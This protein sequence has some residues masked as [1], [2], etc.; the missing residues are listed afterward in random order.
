[1]SPAPDSRSHGR[2]HERE[3]QWK[4]DDIRHRLHH[5]S[6]RSREI[7]GLLK[8]LIAREEEAISFELTADQPTEK[9]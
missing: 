9:K 5:E 3:T 6:M 7:L 2:D 1:M 8:Q 4:L